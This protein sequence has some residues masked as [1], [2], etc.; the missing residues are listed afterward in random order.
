MRLR[1]NPRAYDIMNEN[2]DFVVIEPESFKN[3]WKNVFGNDN[4]IYI[5][6]GWEREI[7]FMKMPV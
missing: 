2:D 1:N 6:I 7:L 5:E 4:P 3:N